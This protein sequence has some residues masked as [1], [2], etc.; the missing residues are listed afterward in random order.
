MITAGQEEGVQRLRICSALVLL[1][2]N[3][4]RRSTRTKKY[5]VTIHDTGQCLS[6]CFR[7]KTNYSPKKLQIMKLNNPGTTAQMANCHM[8]NSHNTSLAL[9]L[10]ELA[11]TLASTVSTTLNETDSS[12]RCIFSS[13]VSEAY[14]SLFGFLFTVPVLRLKGGRIWEFFGSP[15]ELDFCKKERS[16]I[17]KKKKNSWSSKTTQGHW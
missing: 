13:P 7:L 10:L 9:V 11:P 6:N 2:V 16:S 17:E 1:N 5:C 15:R 8:K 14:S 3:S 12:H 4:A